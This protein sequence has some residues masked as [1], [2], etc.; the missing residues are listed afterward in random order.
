M[1]KNGL[2]SCR[3]VAATGATESNFFVRKGEPLAVPSPF[4]IVS[5][6]GTKTTTITVA[7]TGRTV[8]DSELDLSFYNNDGNVFFL[9]PDGSPFKIEMQNGGNATLT[10][11]GAAQL[12]IVTDGI[13]TIAPVN[14]TTGNGALRIQNGTSCPFPVNFVTYV[15]G[16][17][18]GGLTIGNLQTYAYEGSN[19]NKVLDISPLGNAV[20]IGSAATVGGAVV[21]IDGPSG[22]SRVLDPL[23]NPCVTRQFVFATGN[24][25]SVIANSPVFTL[26]PGTYQINCEYYAQDT[27]GYSIPVGGNLTTSLLL[28][29]PPG[30]SPPQFSA[31]FLNVAMLPVPDIGLGPVIV[32]IQSGIFT[33]PT[34]GANTFFLAVNADGQDW[35]FGGPVDSA[36]PWGMN[37]QIVRF[38]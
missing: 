5:A 6:D 20:S 36:S 35:N 18:S 3:D 38:R 8:I 9:A 30:A 17:D 19:I 14:Q 26:V 4:E 7:N 13:T 22:V 15:G 25:L 33:I 28:S 29:G 31:T 34:I 1:N 24:V 21:S 32:N 27:F 16:Q 23:Y 10:T 12:S 11:S 37:Y 2:L